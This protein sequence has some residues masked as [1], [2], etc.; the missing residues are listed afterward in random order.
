MNFSGL[1]TEEQP[2]ATVHRLSVEL[3]AP[4]TRSP[5]PTAA[6]PDT[7]PEIAPHDPEPVAAPPAS[8]APPIKAEYDQMRAAFR[9][10]A[11]VLSARGLLAMALSGA[12]CLALVSVI[13]GGIL[14]LV[15]LFLYSASTIVP[16]VALE[17]HGRRRAQAGEQ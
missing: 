8:P 4:K 5:P 3:V 14:P 13:K 11:F 12:F 10:A 6:T 2:T 7:T 1:S 17:I 15:A 9:V 16:L